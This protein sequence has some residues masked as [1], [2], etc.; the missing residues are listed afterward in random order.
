MSTFEGAYTSLLQGV[1][2]QL[3]NERLPGQVTSQVNMLSDPV[4]NLRRRPGVQYRNHLSWASAVSGKMLAWY[5]DIAGER[6]HIV[7][8][9]AD[10]SLR[11]LDSNLTLLH[12]LSGGAYLTTADVKNIRTTTVGDEF[13]LLNTEKQPTVTGS[14]GAF[15]PATGGFFYVVSGSFGRAYTITMSDSGVSA[16]YSYTTPSGAGAGDAALATPE[17]IATQLYNQIVAGGLFSVYRVSAY[18]FTRTPSG[19]T[20]LNVNTSSGSA[21]MV[22]SKQAYVSQ[23]GNLPAQ[24]PAEANG[25]VVKVGDYSRP[26]YYVYDHS[27]TAW[28]ECG[29]YGSPTGIINMPVSITKSGGTWTLISSAFEGRLAGD[30]TTNEHPRFVTSKLTGIGTFQGRLVLLS[31]PMVRMSASS[32]PRRMYRTTVTAV[33]ASDP[34]D[35]GSSMGSS[36]A[37]E[38]AVSF[39]KDLILF[40]S[41]YQ[42]VV[43]SNNQVVTPSNA[44]VVPT[45]SYAVDTNVPP[46]PIGRT[47]LYPAPR[48]SDF[49]GVMELFP[50][51]YMDTQYVSAD[52]T[53]HLPKYFGGRCRFAAASSVAG[54]ALFGSTGDPYSVQVHEYQWDGDKKVQQAW[55][56][57]EFP[58]PVS[59][60]YF[61]NDLIVLIFVR[62]STVV[63]GTIDPRIGV[64]T[65][66]AERRPFLDLYST[67]AYSNHTVTPPA[68]LLSFDPTCLPSVAL[69]VPSGA[70]SGEAIGFTAN[71]TTLTT[72]KSFP[73]G[74]ASIGFPYRSSLTPTPPVIRDYKD[75]PITTNKATLLRYNLSTKNSSE[76][77][78][79]VSDVNSDT[80]PALDVPTLYWSSS[81]LQLGRS[82]YSTAG[83]SVIPCRTNI[84]ST[85]VEV[86]TEGTGEL[87][88]TALEYVVRYHQKIQRR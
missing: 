59:T 32:K 64:L 3:P 26:Q 69:S 13:F 10:G 20:N 57:W 29:A 27:K 53:V 78:V 31:G 68:W 62:N 40:S 74:S 81:E 58:Y 70:L 42:A 33:L 19:R 75:L 72:V 25:Y 88:I 51:P 9:C 23:Q 67:V 55:H 5:T 61:A 87:N 54:M 17:Y 12:S 65:F 30:D 43:P 4:T 39:S 7:L 1:S 84:T 50:S 76:F 66:D 15:D 47:M 48:S 86:F 16:T 28:L 83:A 24:L 36:A 11:I 71:A 22:A 80:G 73:S 63:F 60:A 41:T 18:L 46:I 56:L 38:Y 85:V 35:I 44:T 79:A 77:K 21:Y 52:S 82:K 6:V 14:T 2:Q 45:S 37:Y 49:F 34:I 8:N